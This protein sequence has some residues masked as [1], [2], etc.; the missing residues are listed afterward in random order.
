MVRVFGM[1][2]KMGFESPSGRDILFL[3]NFDTFRK[4]SVRESKMN[5]DARAQLSFQMFI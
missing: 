1:N 2:T 5:A 4:T 3:K